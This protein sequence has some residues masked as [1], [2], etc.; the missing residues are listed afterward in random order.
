MLFTVANVLQAS[1]SFS[2]PRNPRRLVENTPMVSRSPRRCICEQL[3]HFATKAY[4]DRLL[5]TKETVQ[6]TRGWTRPH[7]AILLSR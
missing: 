6:N 5:V 7:S 3:V 2:A 1:A 4:S